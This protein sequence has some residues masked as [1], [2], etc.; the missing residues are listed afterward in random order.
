MCGCISLMFANRSGHTG[1][2]AAAPSYSLVGYSTAA[3]HTRTIEFERKKNGFITKFCS[4]FT[5]QS[6][7]RLGESI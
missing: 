3:V 2:R 7:Q 4:K 6:A 5:H 1:L